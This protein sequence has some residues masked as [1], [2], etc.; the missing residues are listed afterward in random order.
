MGVPTFAGTSGVNDTS[1]VACA[2]ETATLSGNG[3]FQSISPSGSVPTLCCDPGWSATGPAE[4]RTKSATVVA[5]SVRTKGTMIAHGHHLCVSR[6]DEIT[7]LTPPYRQQTGVVVLNV[8][9]VVFV[10][11]SPCQLEMD[12]KK[13]LPPV[14]LFQKPAGSFHCKLV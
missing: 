13:H 9:K 10:G 12:W 3:L 1:E 5:A 6:L 11:I 4:C 7:S 2:V 14:Q 8:S